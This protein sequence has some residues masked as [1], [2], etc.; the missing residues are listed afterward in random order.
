MK[1]FIPS[2]HPIVRILADESQTIQVTGK[3]RWATISSPSPF[4]SSPPVVDALA[5]HIDVV[6]A[7]AASVAV[8]L[9]VYGVV[10]REEEAVVEVEGLAVRGGGG[11]DTD[12]EVV[13]EDVVASVEDDEE[14]RA[15]ANRFS[16]VCQA[17]SVTVVVSLMGVEVSFL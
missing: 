17:S 15:A 4:P 12:G 3:E 13:R 14:V 10:T 11:D 16:L 1:R 7:V 5:T 6:P 8:V 2:D 9:A